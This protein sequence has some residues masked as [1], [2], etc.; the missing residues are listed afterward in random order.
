MNS[1]YFSMHVACLQYHYRDQI[2]IIIFHNPIS[3]T[4][5]KHFPMTLPHPPPPPSHRRHHH[6]EFFH[7]KCNNENWSH[8]RILIENHFTG[9]DRSM[10][11]C[12]FTMIIYIL[13]MRRFNVSVCKLFCC[14]FWVLCD[15]RIRVS[16]K[17]EQSYK[18]YWE[19]GRD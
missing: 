17:W 1:K 2:N 8:R 5:H 15:G 16:Q 3:L 10:V 4:F 6:Q 9:S 19:Q 12:S 18:S 14:V 13:Y 7:L 11:H